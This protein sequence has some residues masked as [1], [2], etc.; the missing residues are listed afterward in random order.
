MPQ[1]SKIGSTVSKLT[2]ALLDLLLFTDG[3]NL[4]IDQWLLKMQE[5]F[6]I[7]WD[8]YP[9]KRN[10]LIYAENRVGRK[11]L[12]HLESCFWLN[13][14]TSFTTINDLFNYFKDIFGNLHRKEHAME[15]FRKLK[16]GVSLFDDFDSE[17]IQLAS[18][19]EYI[20]EILIWEFNHKLTP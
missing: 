5:K 14:I 10:K 13:S 11:A 8:H 18:K 4:P 3:K 16:M 15:K 7:N 20:L 17:F 12:Q 1:S 2:K 19:L 9:S 6:E